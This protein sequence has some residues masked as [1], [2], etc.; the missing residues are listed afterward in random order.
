MLFLTLN[1]CYEKCYSITVM[2]PERC[3][4]KSYVFHKIKERYSNVIYLLYQISKR[5]YSNIENNETQTII[6]HILLGNNKNVTIS[7]IY[8]I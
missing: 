2:A 5:K 3:S 8:G 7:G 1:H 6:Q 4:Y